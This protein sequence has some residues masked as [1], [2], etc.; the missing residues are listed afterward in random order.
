[1]FSL[2]VLGAF[3]LASDC[4]PVPPA[5]RQRRRLGLLAIL[6]VAGPRGSSRERIQAYLW[7]EGSGPSSR[8]ALDQLLYAT[9]RALDAKPFLSSGGEIR[10]DASIIRSDV[11]DFE[12]AVAGSAWMEAAARYGGPLLDGVHLSDGGDLDRWIEG[13]RSRL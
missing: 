4:G 10:L 13:E 3:T 8:H 9:A 5:A 6:A 1:M 12:D 2:N 11:G 7:P